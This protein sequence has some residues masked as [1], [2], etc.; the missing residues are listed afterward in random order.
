M[1][2]TPCFSADHTTHIVS[3]VGRVYGDQ[4]EF[5]LIYDYFSDGVSVTF[6]PLQI[7]F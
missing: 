7:C 3:I 6:V 2:F 4:V 5:I 1:F